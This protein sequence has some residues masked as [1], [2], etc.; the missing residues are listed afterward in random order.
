MK[1]IENGLGSSETTREASLFDFR[2]FYKY[3]QSSHV[4]RISEAFLEWLLGFYEGDGYIG[5]RQRPKCLNQNARLELTLE[6]DQ[7]EKFLK[8]FKKLLVLAI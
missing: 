5:F 6:I 3:G 8:S 2:D 7:K 1:N 4:S